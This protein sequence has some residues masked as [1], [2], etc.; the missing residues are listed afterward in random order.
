MTG[1][2]EA[3][4]ESIMVAVAVARWWVLWDWDGPVLSVARR[5]IY[6]GVSGCD[7]RQRAA[8]GQGS[9]IDSKARRQSGCWG[10]Q[11]VTVRAVPGEDG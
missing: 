2:S 5:G 11:S 9:R 10:S 3:G 6:T 8:A 1:Y 4:C 7:C